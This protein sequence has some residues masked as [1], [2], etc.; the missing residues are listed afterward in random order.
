MGG[1]QDGLLWLIGGFYTPGAG[2]LAPVVAAV[3]TLITFQQIKISLRGW[4]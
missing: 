2:F 1:S 4:Y 3:E